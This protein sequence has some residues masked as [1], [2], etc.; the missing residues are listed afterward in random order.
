MPKAIFI[1]KDGTLLRDIPYNIDTN[2]IVFEE[3]ARESL[4]LFKAHGY[5][6]IMISNQSGIARGYF[7]E[8]DLE[9]VKQYIQREFAR[10]GAG[11]D[12]FYFCPHH[13][14]GI[15]DKYSIPCTC[16]KPEP[17]ML[18]KA[19]DEHGIDLC[20]SW[21]IGDILHDVEA[22]NRAGCKTILINNGNETEWRRGPYREPD[23]RVSNL[24]QAAEVILTNDFSLNI[25]EESIR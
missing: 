12:G 2:R 15:V 22:G 17:G 16:R 20:Q 4:R 21:M 14:C 23:Y 7:D 9:G 10:V 8:D 24:L 25:N 5:L 11:F 3:T 6:L 13:P 1:D 18:F 19:A